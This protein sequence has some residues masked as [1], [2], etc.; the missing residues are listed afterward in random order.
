MQI[1][2][3]F[4]TKAAAKIRGGVKPGHFK[5]TA[6][7]QTVIMPPPTKV[8]IAM[9]QHIGA[10]CTPIVKK[11]DFVTVGQVIGDSTALISAPIHASVSG[12]VCA[13][14]NILLPDGAVCEAVEIESDG[15]MTR[16]PTL[17]PHP[18]STAGDLVRAARASGLVGL[19]GA[20]FP[21]HVKLTPNDDIKLDTLIVNGAECEPFIT[22]DYRECIEHPDDL[23]DGILLIKERMG[24]G[25]VVIALEDNKPEAVK[26]LK[27]KIEQ[28][29][30]PEKSERTESAAD[31][32][33]DGDSLKIS[34]NTDTEQAI[35]RQDALD[36]PDGTDVPAEDQAALPLKTHAAAQSAAESPV[37][38]MLLPS[39]YPQGAEKM[40]IYAVIGRKLPLGRLPAEVGCL[41]MNLSSVAFLTRYVRTGMPLVTRRLTVD[42]S[43]VAKPM[44]VEV[45]IGT[46]VKDVISFC[47]GYRCTPQKLIT[48]GPMMGFALMDDNL[49]VLKQNNAILA[50]DARDAAV[51]DSTPCIRCGRCTYNCPMRLQPAAIE[52]AL[53]LADAGEMERLGVMYCIECGCCSYICPAKRQ[54]VQSMRVA[55]SKVRKAGGG[56]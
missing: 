14:R 33:D 41:V 16:C 32:P 19:G 13:I 31:T 5:N 2:A 45:P 17:Q 48:G 9:R 34:E 49:P 56:R 37:K 6:D 12:I 25:Q 24:I 46:S 11:G 44:N 40:L 3:S 22:S 8:T 50:F 38:I 39:R 29:W 27:D 36:G 20:G 10:P 30:V 15:Q 53:K 35:E 51:P 52:T 28:R 54:L 42:G 4:I 1:S 26:I 23:L 7:C 43:A 18:V 21:A 47:G 55:K